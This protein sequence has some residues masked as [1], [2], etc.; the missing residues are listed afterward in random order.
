MILRKY[1]KGIGCLNQAA[2][3]AIANDVP[4]DTINDLTIANTQWEDLDW[5]IQNVPEQQIPVV[6]WQLQNLEEGE[7][8]VP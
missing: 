4:M 1:S 6:Q 8:I 7:V 2:I 3:A 5:A